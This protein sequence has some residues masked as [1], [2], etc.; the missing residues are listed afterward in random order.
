MFVQDG[1]TCSPGVRHVRDVDL[2][3]SAVSELI[4]SGMDAATLYP[5]TAD[6]RAELSPQPKTLT[7][8]YV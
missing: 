1:Y 5:P 4:P 6:R 7:D 3:N 2:E 8:G